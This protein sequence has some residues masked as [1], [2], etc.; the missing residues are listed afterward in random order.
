MLGGGHGHHRRGVH[1]QAGIK[2]AAPGHGAT[3]KTTV[4][5]QAMAF[6]GAGRVPVLLTW[7]SLLLGWG[8][9]G[10]WATRL[11]Q[12]ALHVPAL[13]SLPALG[14][15]LL[16]A[17]GAAKLTALA[18]TS[19]L[20]SEESFVT[21]TLDLYGLTGEV[22][23]PVDEARGRVRVYDAHGTLHDVTAHVA[24]GQ[25]PVARGRRVLVRT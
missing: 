14:L 8:L 11:L 15:A 12:P 17:L 4:A 20:P 22:T 3:V 6:F 25:P 16:G 24:P 18:W 9:F 23:F 13:F 7:G 21:G 19:L 5:K 10:F 2:H 1:H